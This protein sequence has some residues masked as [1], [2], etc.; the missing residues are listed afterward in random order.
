MTNNT[1][2]THPDRMTPL[3]SL[4]AAMV[5]FS[6]IGAAVMPA[7][8]T[9][10]GQAATTTTVVTGVSAANLAADNGPMMFDPTEFQARYEQ[11]AASLGASFGTLDTSTL[12]VP[13]LDTASFGDFGTLDTSAFDN[14]SSY[15]SAFFDHSGLDGQVAATASTWAAMVGSMEMPQLDREELFAGHPAPA[16]PT[17]G[18]L[19]GIVYD[20]SLANFFNQDGIASAM[21]TTGLSDSSVQAAWEQSV[22]DATAMVSQSLGGLLPNS[23]YAAFLSSMSGSESLAA[24]F[25]PE[26]A[27]CVTSGQYL[28]SEMQRL[29]DPTVDSTFYDP[30]DNV[31]TASE[32]SQLQPWLQ[33]AI[34]SQNS[35]Y[36]ASKSGLQP[37]LIDPSS[38]SACM[39]A[40]QAS[41]RVVNDTVDSVMTRLG[42]T[43]T[44]R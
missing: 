35:D 5:A 12:A 16:V 23:C 44:G 21:Q 19:F 29:I 25:P 6:L 27:P 38:M 32:Y 17:D 39:Q 43:D 40:S 31:L 14:L 1:P 20:Q 9:E 24:D 7:Y 13:A 33:D 18:L 8:A 2:S 11:L 26:C 4:F 34:G 42:S 22:D 30:S 3:W 36:A 15:V 37:R 28:S 10:D 41:A